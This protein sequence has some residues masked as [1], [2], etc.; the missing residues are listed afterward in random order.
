M[1]T[2]IDTSVFI[3][4][5]R[6]HFDLG[7]WLSMRPS[8]SF[9]ISAVTASELLHGVYRAPPGKR[10]AARRAFVETVLAT[11][12]VHAFDAEA[13]ALH[14]A[15]WAAMAARGDVI[16]AHDLLI[17]ATALLH[18]HAVATFNGEDFA[19]VPGLEVVVPRVP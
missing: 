8:E 7:A 1:G 9:A 19:R 17:A 4:A 15:K 13:A 18:G 3:S 14:A 6:G 10:R 2:L 5:E 16:G 11:Y 12:P